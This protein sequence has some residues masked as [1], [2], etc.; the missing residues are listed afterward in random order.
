MGTEL[1]A[2]RARGTTEKG[3]CRGLRHRRVSVFR[4]SARE[5]IS[6]KSRA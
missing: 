4:V 2:S 6:V 3:E 5:A 1:P